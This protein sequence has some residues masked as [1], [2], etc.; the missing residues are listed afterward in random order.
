MEMRQITVDTIQQWIEEGLKFHLIDV[1]E[2]FEHEIFNLGG[3]LI[4]LNEI[5]NN[6][7][8]IPIDIPVV[9]YCKKGIRS[10]IAIQRLLQKNKFTNL[11]NLQGGTT[12][13]IEKLNS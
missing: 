13:W 4:P 6:V 1:R 7:L 8:Q 11:Y 2:D 10:Q 5:T 12:A 3:Q 9:I